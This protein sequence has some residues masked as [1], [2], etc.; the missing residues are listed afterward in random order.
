[1]RAQDSAGTLKLRLHTD[2]KQ[3][4]HAKDVSAPLDRI[5]GEKKLDMV[6]RP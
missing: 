4:H 2:M 6:S 1:V 3:P 5:D